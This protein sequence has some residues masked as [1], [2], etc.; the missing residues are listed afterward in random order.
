MPRVSIIVLNWNGLPYLEECL[1]S[2]RSQTYRDFELIVV[3]NFSTDGSRE[4]L[5]ERSGDRFGLIESASNLGY[6]GGNNLGIKRAV[7]E[8]IALVNNDAVADRFWLERAM[9]AVDREGRRGNVGMVASK[10]LLYNQRDIIDNTGHLI[11]PDGLN[12][13]RGRLERDGGQYNAVADALFPSGCAA[14]Y[15]REMIVETGGF[16]ERFFAYG[17][18]ADI[19]LRG[20]LLGWRCIFAPR[21]IVYHL[22]SA[23]TSAYS[24]LKAYHVE[25]NRVWVM[26]KLF[27]PAMIW[28]S[29]WHTLIRYGLQAWGAITRRG[30][31]GLY[32]NEK[33]ALSLLK[34]LLKSQWDAWFE[35]PAMLKARRE[36]WKK[37]KMSEDDFAALLMK[38]RIGALE[39]SLSD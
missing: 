34:T 4:W 6:A 28:K 21:A 33:G 11:Y 10:V 29:A 14:L 23:S 12:R 30:A 15:R 37:A 20:R 31:A 26:L 39:I 9:Q 22:Y 19:G 2:L 5:R 3:D 18:D 27:P 35:A 38:N 8:W 25:R 16:D 32:T 24:P 1:D 17:D 7:G 36:I 13:G